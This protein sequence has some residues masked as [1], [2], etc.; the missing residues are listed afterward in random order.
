MIKI[1]PNKRLKNRITVIYKG[2]PVASGIDFENGYF[3]IIPR[4]SYFHESDR[5]VK[6]MT[7]KQIETLCR[8]SLV[9]LQERGK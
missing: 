2:H 1:V 8:R 7:V 3:E 9:A 4:A 6:A 5:D